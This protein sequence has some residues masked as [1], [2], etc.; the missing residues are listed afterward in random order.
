MK[1]NIFKG[2]SIAAAAAVVS[3]TSCAQKTGQDKTL[4]QTDNKALVCYFSATGTTAKAAHRIAAASG[5]DIHEIVPEQHY[6]SA[7]LDWRDSTSRSYVEMHNRAIRPALADSVT[8]I[9]GYS[10][11]FIGYPNWWN[12]APTI[13]NTFIENNDLSGK[14]II[15]FMT[16][17]GSNITNSEKELHEAYPNLTWGKGLLMNH[18]DD[19][20]LTEWVNK[21]LK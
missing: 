4:E 13:I 6:T 16:S 7:D 8:D 5:A 3:L 12:T 2:L 14:T 10:V 19:T 17:G 15:P 21:Y 18:V 1:K 9:S 11:V 20:E